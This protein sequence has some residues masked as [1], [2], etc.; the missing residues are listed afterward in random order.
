ML[1]RGSL[2]HPELGSD[3][4]IWQPDEDTGI[5]GRFVLF[6]GREKDWIGEKK[7]ETGFVF[8]LRVMGDENHNKGYGS[9]MLKEL[10]DEARRRQ[11]KRVRL[12]VHTKNAIA[13]RVYE[14]T[15]FWIEDVG[16]YMH[17]MLI[18]L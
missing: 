8:N 10:V 12:D 16:T 9:L 4:Y 17:R 13:I 5:F 3:Q 18:V 1:T 15:G 11:M 7:S 14:K 2:E 6:N